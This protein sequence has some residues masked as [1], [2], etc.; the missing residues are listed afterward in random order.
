[1]PGATTNAVRGIGEADER[2]NRA[3]CH[4]AEGA[5]ESGMVIDGALQGDFHSQRLLQHVLHV[6]G[7]RLRCQCRRGAS[8]GQLSAGR[9]GGDDEE[10]HQGPASK[11]VDSFH[12]GGGM[13][14]GV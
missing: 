4:A 1:M 7:A 11:G 5:V 6:N 3:G 8:G 9:K 2:D 10:K 13:V 14:R 12:S